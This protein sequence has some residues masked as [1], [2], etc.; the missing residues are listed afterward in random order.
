MFANHVKSKSPLF[1]SFFFTVKKFF[2][3]DKF[4]LIELLVIKRSMLNFAI[5]MSLLKVDSVICYKFRV[6]FLKVVTLDNLGKGFV[7]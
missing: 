5:L 2:S 3:G 4:K 1:L 7:K 6:A